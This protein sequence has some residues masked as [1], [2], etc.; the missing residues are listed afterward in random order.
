MGMLETPVPFNFVENLYYMGV[1]MLAII[2]VMGVLIGI[3]T[4]LNKFF[5]RKKNDKNDK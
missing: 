5:S 1:G 4:L 2:F 3:T